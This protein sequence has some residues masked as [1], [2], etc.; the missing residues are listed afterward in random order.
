MDKTHNRA[1]RVLFIGGNCLAVNYPFKNLVTP[2]RMQ[3]YFKTIM[4]G[5][6]VN[7]TFIKF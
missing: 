7:S 1:A 6:G 2:L 4:S 3:I 5:K